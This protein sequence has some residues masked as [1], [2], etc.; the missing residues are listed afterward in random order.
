LN[1]T[2]SHIVLPRTKKP[3][4]LLLRAVT[5]QSNL[6][7]GRLAGWDVA[8]MLAGFLFTLT[9]T[10]VLSRGRIFWEDEMLGWMLLR[11]PSWHHMVYAWRM[12]ADGGGFTFYLT[13][14]A[15]F[16]LFGPSDISFRL[17]SSTCFGLA[18]AATWAA[19]RRY[20]STGIVAFALINT[21]FFSPTFILHM[22]E[23]RFYGLL[24]L[25]VSLAIWLA[26]VVANAPSPTPKR[27]YA[28][29]FAVH[30]LLTTSH[31]LGVVFSAFV[32]GAIVLTD[33][34][35]KRWRPLLYLSGAATWLF[36]LFERDNIVASARVGKPHFWTGP[37]ALMDV[38]H[39]YTSWSSEI[40]TV[41]SVLLCILVWTLFRS[42]QRWA[43]QLSQAYTERKP[44]YIVTA[45]ILAIPIAFLVEGTVGTW[46]FTERYLLPVNIAIA[47]FT[48]EVSSLIFSNSSAFRL[49]QKKPLLL[50]IVRVAGMALYVAALLFWDF[51]HVREFSPSA[52]DYTTALNAELPKG[53]PIVCEDAF[54]FTELIGRQHRTGNRYTFLLDWQQSIS[55]SAP[56]L[57]VTQ[58]HLM[59]NW[60]NVGYFS[61][62]I[63][64]IQDFLQQNPVFMVVHAGVAAPNGT[65]EIG[66][67]LAERFRSNPAYEIKRHA[68]LNRKTTQDVIWLVCRGKCPLN[69]MTSNAQG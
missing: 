5:G 43:I 46:L 2:E 20:Y 58:Y 67:P 53:I 8:G 28:A 21:W 60:K 25:A 61:G 49:L 1:I 18:F 54:T 27:L 23:G 63:E 69:I 32:L 45:A 56:R 17:Y 65:P 9:I 64:P 12:G 29:M 59:E 4:L 16:H 15:W 51:H 35:S 52:L 22:R 47:Y 3:K 41:L 6:R 34:L 57:E 13:G 30:T 50:K 24:T 39:A 42:E 7:I 19:A 66:N 10:Y 40:A 11:D 37:P 31:L 44:V 36:L 55:P 68:V 14:R 26:L 33:L 48:A 62:S 38:F